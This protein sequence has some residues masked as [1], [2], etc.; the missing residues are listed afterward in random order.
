MIANTVTSKPTKPAK[1]KPANR[2][3]M[4]SLTTV[5]GTYPESASDQQVISIPL[6]Q[7][8]RHP[9]NRTI[10]PNSP[11]IVELATSIATY[12]QMEPLRVRLLDSERPIYEII[13]GERRYTALRWGGHAAARAIVVVADDRAALAEVAV[14]NSHRQDLNPIE[15]AQLM[16]LLMAPPPKGSDYS[17][18]QAGL[19]FGL[20]STSGCKN[21]LRLLALPDEIKAMIIDGRMPER[22]ARRLVPYTAAPKVMHEIVQELTREYSRDEAMV[23]LWSGEGQPHF[24]CEAIHQHARPLE[25]D[26]GRYYHYPIGKA[27]PCLFDWSAKVKELEV[28]ELPTELEDDNCNSGKSGKTLIGLRKYALNT[29]LWD[30]L[31]DPLVKAAEEER[32]TSSGKSTGKK[33]TQAK[34]ADAKLTPAQEAAEAR[35]RAAEADKRLETF[36]SDWVDRLLRCSLA[37]RSSDDALVA[38]TL[39]WI[40]SQCSS[41]DLRSAHDQALHECQVRT[42]KSK[43]KSHSWAHADTLTALPTVAKGPQTRFD[44]LNAFWRV[45]LWPVTRL[46]GDAAPSSALTPAG[47]LPDKLLHLGYGHESMIELAALAGVSVETAWREGATDGTD[48]RRL[49]SVWLCR[50]TK[51]Q[52]HKLRLELHVTEGSESMAREELAHCVLNGHRP[53]RP[54]PLP[55]RL[56]KQVK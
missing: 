15:R 8:R 27:Y 35:R 5:A 37:D 41:H 55:K 11:E 38:L 48:Q 14:A 25:P 30:K 39:P 47:E 36:T 22:V 24:I 20:Q 2:L 7:L 3:D 56:T 40:V 54:L 52:L 12:G 31:Q 17:L 45:I 32:K 6:D 46:V 49:I 34:S 50:H 43:S 51:A 18:E 9:A 4:S 21:A 44:V 13:S 42:P 33:G 16:Q 1:R 23:E 19:V 28:V 10:D 53:G 29:K 26:V